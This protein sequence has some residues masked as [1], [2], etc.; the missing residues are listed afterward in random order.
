MT[1]KIP[2]AVS[3]YMANIGAKGRAVASKAQQ[4]AAREN[5]KKGGRP[6]KKK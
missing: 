2:S 5:G 3:D 4:E 1:S 6:R